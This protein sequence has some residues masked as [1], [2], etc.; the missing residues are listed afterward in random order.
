MTRPEFKDGFALWEA[1][2]TEELRRDIAARCAGRNPA[3]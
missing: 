2:R 1:R 3:K